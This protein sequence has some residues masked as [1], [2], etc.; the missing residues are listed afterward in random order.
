MIRS[1]GISTEWT[2]LNI[3]RQ[4]QRSADP[5][6]PSETLAETRAARSDRASARV[7]FSAVAG[8]TRWRGLPQPGA[9]P[10]PDSPRARVRARK[11]PI[12]PTAARSPASPI[13]TLTEPWIARYSAAFREFPEKAPRPPAG[14]FPHPGTDEPRRARRGPDG[15]LIGVFTRYVKGIGETGTEA[16]R[17]WFWTVRAKRGISRS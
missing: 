13:P 4:R 16:P 9:G 7:P 17:A 14:G 15:P 11:I 8:M 3:H 2:L 5:N 1:Y 12:R 6:R 10:H